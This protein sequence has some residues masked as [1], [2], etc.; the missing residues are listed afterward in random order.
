IQPLDLTGL[1]DQK[2]GNELESPKTST[3]RHHITIPKPF[4]MCER[5]ERTLQRNR[6][7]SSM[8]HLL[9][10][11]ETSGSEITGTRPASQ[12]RAKPIPAHVYLPLYEHL[13]EQQ[14]ERREAIRA[15]RKEMLKATEKPFKFTIRE[16]Q[17]KERGELVDKA[18]AHRRSLSLRRRNSSVDQRKSTKDRCRDTMDLPD[19]LY[20]NR[21]ERIHEDHLLREVKRQLRAQRLLQSASLPAGM[22]ER[23]RRAAK[24]RADRANREK[25]RGLDPDL[26]LQQRA[27]KPFRAKPAPDFKTIHWKTD[28]SLRRIW[29]PPPDPTRPK[30]FNLLTSKRSRSA[31]DKQDKS[32][33]TGSES[34]DAT[35]DRKQRSSSKKPAPKS[36]DFRRSLAEIPSPAKAYS[37]MLRENHVRQSMEK[38]RLEA[39]KAEEAEQERRA[40]QA[41][42]SRLMRSSACYLGDQVVSPKQLVAAVTEN[43]KRMLI[44]EDSARQAEYQ[45]EL[46]EMRKRVA[47]RPLLITRQSQ[48][49]AR[50]RAENQFAN[51]LRQAGLDPQEVI[52][53]VCDVSGIKDIGQSATG[54]SYE[55]EPVK[56]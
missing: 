42:V 51:T 30:P 11:R 49:I 1:D 53:N 23:E 50:Q 29:Q 2:S 38:A 34:A 36:G 21:M 20:E 35:T 25:K 7:S 10:D 37:S 43:R 22:E 5:E 52:T 26:E 17:K 45:R 32:T 39:K 8:Q 19:H 40:K 15:H 3:W 41:E 28:Q 13:V 24:R 33:F 31:T 54:Q 27:A 55:G 44:K 47:S 56:P 4:K 48:V 12:F 16:Q 46:E 18:E 9:A 6:K 14:A